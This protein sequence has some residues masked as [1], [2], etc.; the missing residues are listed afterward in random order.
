MQGLMEEALKGCS[1]FS[2]SWNSKPTLFS[3]IALT[4]LVGP[5][6]EWLYSSR[7]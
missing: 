7:F 5:K 4:L 2:C 6:R 1:K 3:S